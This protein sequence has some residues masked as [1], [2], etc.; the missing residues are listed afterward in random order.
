[1]A[2]PR[3][4][5]SMVG[6]G[7]AVGALVA[8][9]RV[10]TFPSYGPGTRAIRTA[11]TEALGEHRPPLPTPAALASLPL[12]LDLPRSNGTTTAGTPR[13]STFEPGIGPA[14]RAWARAAAATE[15]EALCAWLEARLLTMRAT[16]RDS[17]YVTS[18][19]LTFRAGCPPVS[20][21]RAVFAR[22][23]DGALDL[24]RLTSNCPAVAASDT[25][26]T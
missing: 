17:V 7:V 16:R 18:R 21:L 1:M 15:P 2:V 5:G 4:I 6:A 22:A 9:L 11:I 19:R 12:T 8:A 20:T 3:W 10:Y 24:V 25:L 23:P 13:P 26:P 14:A